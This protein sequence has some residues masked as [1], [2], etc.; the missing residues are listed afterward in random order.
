MPPFVLARTLGLSALLAAPSFADDAK[1]PHFLVNGYPLG[2]ARTHL[3]ASETRAYHRA[4]AA[5]PTVAACLKDDSDPATAALNLEA[6]S[7]L[8]E[9]EVCLFLTADALRDLEG[10]RALLRRSGFDTPSLIH[11]PKSNMEFYGVSGDGRAV[12][13]FM[14][15]ADAPVGLVGWLDRIFQA[16]GISAQVLFGPNTEPVTTS[17]SINRL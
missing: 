10:T 16:H 8:E 9:L 15:T 1:S 13:G 17:A 5:F 14:L 3:D 4:L 2:D 7:S 11:H 6:F 12:S